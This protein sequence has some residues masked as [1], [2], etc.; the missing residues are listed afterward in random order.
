MRL[1]KVDESMPQYLRDKEVEFL[2][3]GYLKC[4]W[5]RVAELESLTEREL[6]RVAESTHKLLAD[7]I[8]TTT[9]LKEQVDSLKARLAARD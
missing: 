9:R 5:E 6:K 4:P 8:S 1:A 2:R 7:Q 3:L